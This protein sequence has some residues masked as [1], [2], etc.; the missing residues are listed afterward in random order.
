[1]NHVTVPLGCLPGLSPS[2]TA[3][4]SLKCRWPLTALKKQFPMSEN[5]Y[6]KRF[7]WIKTEATIIA[8]LLGPSQMRIS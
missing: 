2:F 3:L 7:T 6:G 5:L 4:T 1:M 8:Q